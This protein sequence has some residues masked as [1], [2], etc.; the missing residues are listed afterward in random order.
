MQTLWAA[1]TMCGETRQVEEPDSVKGMP[2][3]C[4]D[5]YTEGDI[6]DMTV[7]TYPKICNIGI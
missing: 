6:G 4:L 1:G 2:E 5:V 7:D 3:S